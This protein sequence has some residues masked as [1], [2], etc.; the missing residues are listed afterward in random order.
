MSLALNNWALNVTLTTICPMLSEVII[1]LE[2]NYK[3]SCHIIK[4]TIGLT[5]LAKTL[6]RLI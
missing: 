6:I 5:L 2:N 4:L 3:M 1:L